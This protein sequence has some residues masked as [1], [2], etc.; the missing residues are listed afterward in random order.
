[1]KEADTPEYNPLVSVAMTTSKSER[2]IRPQLD[3]ILNQ[4]YRNIELVISHDE[5]GDNTV[6]ILNEYKAK[7]PR[8]RW[9]YNKKEK[10]FIKNSEN[11]VSMCKGEILFFADHD[12]TW[13]LDR[14]RTHVEKYKDK[15]VDWVYDRSALTDENNNKIGFLEDQVP[16]YYSKERLTLLNYT[17]GTCI[18]A[19]HSSYRAHL[20][21][22]AM[23]IPEYA[24]GHDSWIQLFIY[25]SKAVFIDK[26]FIQYRQHAGQQ[27]GW[28][29]K[30]TLEEIK[31]REAQAIAGN[32]NYLKCLSSNKNLAF[33]KRNFFL[34]V[35]MAKRIRSFL[36]RHNLYKI[37][38][39]SADYP[40]NL[41]S[42]GK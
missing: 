26:V 37:K 19:A 28:N 2:F 36:A 24:P 23:P 33:W 32:M 34:L 3:S 30:M 15:T 29:H 7:D 41:V 12:D 4:T 17:W 8:V 25:P 9:E 13:Y 14:I 6:A 27:V 20:V 5:C 10:G 21:H 31:I 16:N 38:L 22:Q 40:S 42:A 35:Y 1:M 39:L 11:S 18:G